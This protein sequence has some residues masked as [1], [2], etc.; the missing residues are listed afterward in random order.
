MDETSEP[1]GPSPVERELGL[2]AKV[3]LELDAVEAALHD[4]DAS[5]TEPLAGPEEPSQPP[6]GGGGL[7]EPPAG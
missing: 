7:Y 2:L 1:C 5:L 4:V 3:R 6:R